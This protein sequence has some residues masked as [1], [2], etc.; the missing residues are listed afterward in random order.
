M[1]ETARRSSVYVLLTVVGLGAFLYPFWL[2]PSAGSLDS[3]HSGDAPLIAALAGL[4][5]LGAV[6]LEVR[7]G[8]MTGTSVAV[9]G[10]LSASAGMLKLLD[11]PGGGSG[12]FFLIILA[13][14]AFGLSLIHI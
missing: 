14:A 1:I 9:L 4:L 12:I 11:L 7:R 13:G 5:A 10:V 2:P 6:L 8:T 3:A